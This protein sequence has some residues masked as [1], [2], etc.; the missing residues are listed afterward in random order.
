MY[1]RKVLGSDTLNSVRIR[2]IDNRDAIA[3]ANLSTQLGYP[4]SV[5]TIDERISIINAHPEHYAFVAEDEEGNPL[6][7]IH[8]YIAHLI[9]SPNSYV[10]IGGLVVDEAARG[11]GIG[12]ALVQAAEEWTRSNGM[13]DIRVRSASRRADAHAFY[14]HLG[15][16]VQKTQLRFVKKLENRQVV[17]SPKAASSSSTSA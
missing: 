7:W 12:K 10:E 9:E 15:Y 5:E 4:M 17:A 13:N 3:V 14:Q 6:G 11:K 16:E 8:I 1:S 2:P